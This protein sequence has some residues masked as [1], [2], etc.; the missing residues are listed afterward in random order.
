MKCPCG[1]DR[2]LLVNGKVSD[3]CSVTVGEHTRDG[4]VPRNLNIGG[5]DYLEIEFCLDCGK[6]QGEFPIT[7]AQVLNW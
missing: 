3:M 1:S 4:Y 7:D 6:V 2:L 5:G